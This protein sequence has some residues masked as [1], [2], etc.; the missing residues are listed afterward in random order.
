MNQS[1]EVRILAPFLVLSFRKAPSNVP[2]D[3]T[4]REC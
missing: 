1:N 2:G 3:D 4:D